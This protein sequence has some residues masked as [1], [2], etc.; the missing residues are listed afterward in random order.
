MVATR[1]FAAP[2]DVTLWVSLMELLGM[3]AALD[4]I[5]RAPARQSAR[6][7]LI[8]LI[9]L[10]LMVFGL[11]HWIYV[12]AI[13]GMIPA[14]MPGRP[15]WPWLTGAANLAAGLALASGV[16]ARTGAMLA[17]A[18]FASWIV[19]VHAPRLISAP[20]DRAEW[21]GLALAFALIGVVWSAHAA[22]ARPGEDLQPV[23][24]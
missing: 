20:G 16:L 8:A 14:W 24:R 15:W 7:G 19:L 23:P 2:D 1:L 18:M 9:G 13:A 6:R 11:V 10:M 17:G 22:L 5:H 21:I 4:L 3:A 12:E